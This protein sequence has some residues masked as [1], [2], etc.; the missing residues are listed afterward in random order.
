MASE[1]SF[2][3]VSEID[4][5]E[6]A[7]ALDQVRKEIIVRYDFKGV[8][9]DIKQEDKALTITTADEHK[10]RAVRDI[11]ETKLMRRG[12]DIKI[13]GEAK[14]EPASG[15]QIRSHIPL[16]AGIDAEN[17]KKINKLIRDKFPK[18]KPTIQ[19]ETI[20]VSGKSIDELQAIMTL[21]KASAPVALP[22]QFIN[23]R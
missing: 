10:L 13:L 22:L 19:G 21:L 1:H 23:Y 17:A 3:I 14:N 4:L 7:N 11:L 12:L 15:G 6:L 8:P 5:Q 18:V 20:R 2:D 9:T 16:L